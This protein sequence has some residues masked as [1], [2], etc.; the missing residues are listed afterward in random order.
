MERAFFILPQRR[1]DAEKQSKLLHLPASA[2][3]KT[4]K[5]CINAEPCVLELP[6]K[7]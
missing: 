4:Q 3:L 7:S 6:L 2:V 5:P 1:G